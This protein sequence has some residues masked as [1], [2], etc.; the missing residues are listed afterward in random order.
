MIERWNEVCQQI[1]AA[2]SRLQEFI[3]V[4]GQSVTQ[5]RK[6]QKFTKEWNSVK[7]L[8]ERF[9][10]FISPVDPIEVES[11]FDQE[12]FRYMWRMWKEYLQEQHGMLMRTRMEQSSLDFLSEISDNNPDLAI[13]YLRFAMKSGY[14][15][16]FKVYDKVKN[17]PPKQ[18]KNGSDY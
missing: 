18:D 3:D 17:S 12:D 2:D 6:L 11:P 5:L 9:D 4:S 1:E 8:A 7:K 13:S 14:R 10:Q 16:F 15:G